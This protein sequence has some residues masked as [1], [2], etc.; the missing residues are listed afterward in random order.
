MSKTETYEEIDFEEGNDDT[1]KPDTLLDPIIHFGSLIY[2]KQLI[3]I[4]LLFLFVNTDVFIDK[5]LGNISG[6]SENR[7]ATTKG[8]II[9]GIILCIG[10][11]L[12]DLLFRAGFP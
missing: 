6:A 11:M 9:S 3:A 7:H 10:Y 12:I 8:I 1:K 2:F 5:V 4:F